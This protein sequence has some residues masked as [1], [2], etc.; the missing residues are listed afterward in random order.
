MP[1]DAATVFK[2][3]SLIPDR[4]AFAPSGSA[5]TAAAKCEHPERLAFILRRQHWLGPLETVSKEE[6]RML[7]LMSPHARPLHAADEEGA[8]AGDAELD[9]L[10]PFELDEPAEPAAPVREEEPAS[11]AAL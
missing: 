9:A 5:C 8:E 6:Q 7:G 2:V 11:H 1:M 10:D 3:L 4:L